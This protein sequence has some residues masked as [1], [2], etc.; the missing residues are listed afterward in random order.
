MCCRKPQFLVV[1]L[2]YWFHL[3]CQAMLVQAERMHCWNDHQGWVLLEFQYRPQRVG[4]GRCFEH[5]HQDL[6]FRWLRRHSSFRWKKETLLRVS[7]SNKISFKNLSFYLSV[8]IIVARPPCITLSVD[9]ELQL[10]KGPYSKLLKFLIGRSP[11][12]GRGSIFRVF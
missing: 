5:K 11:S 7:M 1:N 2:N 8:Q 9:V 4:E 3:Q 10:F 6:V 12:Q